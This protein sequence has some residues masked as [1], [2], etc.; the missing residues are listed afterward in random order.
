MQG[1]NTNSHMRKVVLAMLWMLGALFSFTAMALAGRE[2]SGRL[3]TFEMLFF[4]SLIG[5]VVMTLVIFHQPP[6]QRLRHVR[7]HQPVVHLL[8]N[9]SHF[10]G[11]YGWLYAIALIPLAQVFAIEFTIPVWVALLA[12][13]VLGERMSWA[14][15]TAILLGVVGV[16]VI[17]RPGLE[18]VNAGSLAVLGASALY[19][20]ALTLTR[21]LALKD[22]PLSVLFWMSAMQLPFG[23]LL[24]WSVW[25]WPESWMWIW[26]FT[27]GLTSLSAHY[28]MT[29]AFR[30]ADASLVAPMDFLRLPL[31]AVIAWYL[32]D[33]TLDWWVMAGAVIMLIG[34]LI[35]VRAERSRARAVG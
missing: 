24:T 21:K 34:N 29:Q 27:I 19:G 13:F 15:A 35:S 22:T 10:A 31:I 32:Y 17:L 20:F 23:A 9:L 28:C 7:M 4:R 11:Q 8:R 5:L 2:L 33:E 3:N 30:L 18:V 12:P 16:L 26:L 25:Q 14:R 1:A 6:G